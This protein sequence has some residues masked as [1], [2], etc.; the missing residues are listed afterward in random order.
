MMLAAPG[1]ILAVDPG[2]RTCGWSVV[3]PRTGRVIALGMLYQPNDEDLD[4]STCRAR[5]AHQ[6]ARTLYGVAIK[7]GCRVLAAEAMSFG[8]PPSARFT[9]AVSLGLSWG[10]LMGLAATLGL[11]VLEVPPKQWQHAVDPE[12]GKAIDY[13]RIFNLLSDF[14]TGPA[15]SDLHAIKP[16]HRNHALDSVGVGVFASLRPGAAAHITGAT[17]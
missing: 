9:M 17:A 2:L 10:V 5:R 4:D 1:P 6:Q 3:A 7:H 14:I 12:C 15:A 13:E 8:G 11:E 16:A